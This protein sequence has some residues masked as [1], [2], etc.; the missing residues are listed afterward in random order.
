MSRLPAVLTNL[1]LG[2]T[3]SLWATVSPAALAEPEHEDRSDAEISVLVRD[4]ANAGVMLDAPT[5][6]AVIAARVKTELAGQSGLATASDV[7]VEVN[8]GVVRLS[9]IVSTADQRREVE[10]VAR[11][12]AGVTA[13]QNNVEVEPER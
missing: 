7:D 6:D 4:N 2:M 1:S 10:T 3:L 13:V 8:D 5:G 9:G 12:V 11:R